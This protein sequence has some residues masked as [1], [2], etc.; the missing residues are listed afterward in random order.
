MLCFD[1]R[2]RYVCCARRLCLLAVVGWL[3]GAAATSS[4]WA[5][6]ETDNEAPAEEKTPDLDPFA[7]ADDAGP[8]EL[9]THA[10]KLIRLRPSGETREEQ[11]EFAKRTLSALLETG[12]QLLKVAE[13][14]RH[15]QIGVQIKLMSL[16]NLAQMGDEKA[17]KQL[18]KEIAAAKASKK[19]GIAATG[20]QSDIESRIVRWPAASPEDK[21]KLKKE[22]IAEINT[23]TPQLFHIGLIHII[24]QQLADFDN[25]FARELLVEAM[26]LFE[27]SDNADVVEAAKELQGLTRRLN[28]PGNKIKVV[29]QILGGGDIDWDSYRGKVVLVDFWATWCSPCRQEVPNILKMYDSYHKKGFEVVG[30]SLDNEP[31]DA[32]S[33]IDQYK[34]PWVSL[35]SD[36]PSQRGWNHPLARYYAIDGIPTAILVDAEGRVVHMNARDRYL[37]EELRRLLGDPLPSGEDEAV[38]N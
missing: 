19:T 31:E 23:R 15:E 32:Q 38:G 2:P 16:D 26:P 7:I 35:F 8:R 18:V 33:Y 21:L 28:L 4:A 6:E 30:I 24:A 9:I 25:K 12:E 27:K 34:I 13:E 5:Q 20:W 1:L 11:L 17:G 10:Q 3:V 14:S 37:R 29:G 36:D 22:L